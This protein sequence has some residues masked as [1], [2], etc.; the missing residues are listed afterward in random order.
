MS[1]DIP[2]SWL[3]TKLKLNNNLFLGDKAQKLRI[4]NAGETNK[5]LSV[6]KVVP[7]G[8]DSGGIHVG[9]KI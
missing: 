9:T 7:E 2:M 4:C 1:T 3:G 6:F 5:H 8:S